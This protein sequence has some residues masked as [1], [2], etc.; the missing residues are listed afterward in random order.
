MNGV[1]GQLELLDVL[2]IVS[3]VLQLQNQQNIIG[4]RDVQREVDR[5]IGEIHAHLEQQ[6]EK[7]DRLLEGVYE[8][9]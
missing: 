2:T 9:D 7:I 8:A 3:F 1:D 6:D 4:I 5:A